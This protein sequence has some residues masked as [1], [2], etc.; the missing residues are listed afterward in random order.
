MFHRHLWLALTESVGWKLEYLIQA[1]V[2]MEGS[3][4]LKDYVPMPRYYP[5]KKDL[6]HIR[7]KGVRPK[8]S[9]PSGKSLK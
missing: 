8:I 6:P 3:P 1:I 4:A 2:Q 9:E 7:L 5:S